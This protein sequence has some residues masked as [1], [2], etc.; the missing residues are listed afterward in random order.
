MRLLR[1]GEFFQ[2]ARKLSQKPVYVTQLVSVIMLTNSSNLS[3]HGQLAH[4]AQIG[5]QLGYA[6]Y[7]ATDQMLWLAGVG[8]TRPTK[9]YVQPISTLSFQVSEGMILI[10]RRLAAV[11]RISMRC[12]LIGIILSIGSSSASLVKLRADG[13]RFALTQAAARKE[14]TEKSPEEKVRAE[15]ERREKGRALLA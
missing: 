6:G 15:E 3:G 9:E 5:R 7:F 4:F 14:N 12:W 2:A 8:V 11:Q 10:N 1:N 13:R